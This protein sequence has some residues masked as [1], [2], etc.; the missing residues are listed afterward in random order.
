MM[1]AGPEQQLG[2]LPRR[3]ETLHRP[4]PPG[5]TATSTAGA[6]LDV[7]VPV[8]PP[9]ARRDE[10]MPGHPLPRAPFLSPSVHP[11]MQCAQRANGPRFR[12]PNNVGA[13]P[14][15][16]RLLWA[17]MR[18]GSRQRPVV[19]RALARGCV[20]GRHDACRCRPGSGW[21]RV[22]FPGPGSAVCCSCG[23]GDGPAGRMMAVIA[24][25]PSIC[26]ACA[27]LPSDHAQAKS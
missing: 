23:G 24:W 6:C 14:V 27:G 12:G 21:S 16:A 17:T 2:Y 25:G 26:I 13:D 8:S 11:G 7:L 1:V 15:G 20:P 9:T 3:G 5:A 4:V 19:W 22:W 10:G 18:D